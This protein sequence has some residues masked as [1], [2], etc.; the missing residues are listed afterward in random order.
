MYGGTS[1][2]GCF[3]GRQD[4]SCCVTKVSSGRRIV[5]GALVLLVSVCRGVVVVV[6]FDLCCVVFV[7]L[8]LATAEA[9]F[10]LSALRSRRRCGVAILGRRERKNCL[11]NRVC[12]HFAK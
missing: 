10:S 7:C 5:V 12:A 11:C 9:F 3:G 6:P 4:V 1:E 2:G 8:V